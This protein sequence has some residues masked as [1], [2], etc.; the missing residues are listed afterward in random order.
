[1]AE[2]RPVNDEEWDWLQR[3]FA[4]LEY[5]PNMREKFDRS[6]PGSPYTPAERRTYMR[7]IF[8]A[9]RSMMAP[10]EAFPNPW[11][12]LTWFKALKAHPE[13]A[14][15]TTRN[16]TILWNAYFRPQEAPGTKELYEEEWSGL[17]DDET[18]LIVNT[19]GEA[20][21]SE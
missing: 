14:E 18:E 16:R 20:E 15:D 2:Y 13:L 10:T 12:E 8:Q 3:R 7:E 1:M 21:I 19:N 11:F 9:V 4:A 17:V 5:L 6:L